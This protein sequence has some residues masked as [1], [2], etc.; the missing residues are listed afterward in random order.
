M[1]NTSHPGFASNLLSKVSEE[2]DIIEIKEGGGNRETAIEY[3]E[4]IAIYAKRKT[5]L[6]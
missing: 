1:E 6:L 4:N 5:C 3:M 2:I